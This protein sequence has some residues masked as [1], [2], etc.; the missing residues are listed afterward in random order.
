MEQ[1]RSRRRFKLEEKEVILTKPQ[2]KWLRPHYADCEKMKFTLDE[3]I[4]AFD[5]TRQVGEG[6]HNNSN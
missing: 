3:I 4:K 1:K 6:N 2:Q 5:E